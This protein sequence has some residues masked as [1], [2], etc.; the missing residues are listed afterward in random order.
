MKNKIKRGNNMIEYKP[1][2]CEKCKSESKVEAKRT[3]DGK[4]IYFINT[5]SKSCCTGKAAGIVLP[6]E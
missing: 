4:T 3:K 6:K 5:P 1:N 2:E